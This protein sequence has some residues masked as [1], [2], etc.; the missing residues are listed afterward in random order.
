M[1]AHPLLDHLNSSQR[2]AVSAPLGNHLVLAGAGSGKTR[3]LVHR[4]A[5]LIEQEQVSPFSIMAVTFTNKAAHEMRSRIEALQGG[6]MGG[7]W[8]GTFHSLSHRLLRTHW[9]DAGLPETFQI[10]DSDD[11]LRLIKRICRGMGLAEEQWPA[12]KTQWF[13]NQKKDDGH[14]PEHVQAFDHDYTQQMVRIYQAYET[15]CRQAGLVDF[16]EL[17]LRAHELLRDNPTLLAHYQER[18]KHILVDEFQDTNAIQYAWVRL[19][20]GKTGH[21]MVVGD[22]DQSIYGWRGAKV[23]NIQRVDQDF[24]ATQ[25]IRL[26]Q[27]YR[28]TGNI[29]KASNTLIANNGNRLGKTLWT[30]GQDG[31]PISIY[32]AFNEID[33]ARFIVNHIK[34]WLDQGNA[35]SECAILYRSNAQSR[36]LE[37]ALLQQNIAYRVYGGQRFFERM[38]IKDALAYLRLIANRNDDAAF[39]RVINT[40]TRGIGNQTLATLRLYARDNRLSLWQSAIQ[41]IAQDTLA[42]RAVNCL[43]SFLQLID[44]LDAETKT[45]GLGELTEHVIT[46]SQLQTHFQKEK[47][48]KAQARIENLEE[49]VTATNQFTPDPEQAETSSPLVAFLTHAALEAGEGQADNFEDSVQL[50]TLHSAKG[51]EFPQVFM[52]G[53][54]EGLF[55]H[56]MSLEEPGRLEEERRLCYVGMTRAKAKLTI[57]YAETRRLRGNETYNRPSRFIN[58]L[59]RETLQEVRLN[60]TVKRPISNKRYNGGYSR[61]PQQQARESRYTATESDCGLQMGQRVSHKKFGEGVVVGF[62]GQGTH[63]RVQVKFQRAGTKWLVASYAKLETA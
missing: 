36:V 40:P 29:L 18:F 56:N 28:S 34:Q 49:L 5:W 55:P 20:V 3:V 38:E 15:A 16:A 1:D 58:E 51:L 44:R 45:L 31:E 37:E 57:T 12:R 22:D 59:P 4:I 47:G 35:L 8:V 60:S 33:E 42:A 6:G 53:L 27:N 39:E 43:A 61:P 14:R 48:E 17:L 54:E 19:L 21:L 13:I 10:L 11:Q 41:L 24:P 62:E 46:H 26:E 63:A 50:M 25:T 52:A 7:L 32:A 30:D 2:Q 23:E 9:Q